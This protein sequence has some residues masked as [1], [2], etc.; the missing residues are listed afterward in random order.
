MKDYYQIL[1]LEKSATQ[2]EIKAAFRLYASKFHPD[3]QKGDKFF[4]SRFIEIKEA[5]D[6]LSDP[7]RKSVYDK[8]LNKNFGNHN[9]KSSEFYSKKERDL[10][11]KEAELNR[12]ENEFQEKKWRETRERN[13]SKKAHEEQI[14]FKEGNV[15]LSGKTLKIGH[16]SA[17][18]SDIERAEL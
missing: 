3:K 6:T 15:Y 10:R 9:N 18:I 14:Y 11:E 5:Y 13:E 1:G 12:K 7:K 8:S 4:E 17:S 16:G 2:E